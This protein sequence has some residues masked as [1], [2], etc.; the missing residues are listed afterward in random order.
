MR[1]HYCVSSVQSKHT[2]Y[3]CGNNTLHN[4]V[5]RLILC[6]IKQSY[7][8]LSLKTWMDLLFYFAL[9]SAKYVMF[10]K[11]RGEIIMHGTV[12]YMLR[13]AQIYCVLCSSR[14][15]VRFQWLLCREYF[16]ISSIYGPRFH[17]RS[18]L[19]FSF[20]NIFIDTMVHCSFLLWFP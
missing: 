14:Y 3:I 17:S 7:C 13:R 15:C 1:T 2:S 19:L 8:C 16:L 9:L 18:E 20:T 11:T 10:I 6:Y 5:W 12:G 4:D